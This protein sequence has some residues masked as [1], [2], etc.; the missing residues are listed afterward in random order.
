MIRKPVFTML[1]T[2]FVLTACSSDP[3]HSSSGKSGLDVTAHVD[4]ETSSV[5]LPIDRFVMSNW[6]EE[7]VLSA[8][9]IALAKCARDKLGLQKYG[10]P[11][12]DVP[13]PEHLMFNELGVWTPEMADQFGFVKPSTRGELSA[14]GIIPRPKNIDE[15]EAELSAYMLSADEEVE[16]SET[17]LDGA[18]APDLGRFN[19][20][21]LDPYN[22]PWTAE[23]NETLQQ[24]LDDDRVKTVIDDLKKCYTEAGLTIEEPHSPDDLGT[25]GA[26]P[27]R[28]VGADTMKIDEAQIEMANK[29]VACKQ[30]TDAINKIT[31]VWAEKQAPIIEEYADELV[32]NRQDIQAVVADATAYIAEN[33]DLLMPVLESGW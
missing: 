20:V 11:N 33:Q 24:T 7:E 16:V 31:A 5:S 6:E 9:S 30:E 26:L 21:E 8:R 29:V 32:A 13:P 12:Y 27:I 28:I 17:C 14:N 23:I 4:P 10:V 19:T 18:N 2:V 3:E 22:G 15:I 25:D 1:A